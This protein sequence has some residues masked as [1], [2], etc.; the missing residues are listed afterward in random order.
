VQRVERVESV[1]RAQ[2]IFRFRAWKHGN[3]KRNRKRIGK[4]KG[5]KEEE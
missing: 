3:K 5:R 2:P 1:E 4:K